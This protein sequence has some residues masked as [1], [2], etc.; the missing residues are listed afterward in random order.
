[1]KEIYYTPHL[2]LRI[3]FRDI[4]RNLP[5]EIYKEARERYWDTKTFYHIAV[6][7]VEFKGKL[8]EMIVAYDETPDMI[9]IVTIHPL[10]PYQKDQ[11]IKT[12]R[13]RIL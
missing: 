6:K 9:E 12:G 4:P 1:M 2:K 8:R 10:K 3:K 5:E 11:R 13:W 7:G